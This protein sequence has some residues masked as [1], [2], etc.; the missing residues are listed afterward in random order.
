MIE[1]FSRAAA[2]VQAISSSNIR[3]VLETHREQQMN[4]L[5]E[6]NFEQRGWINVLYLNGGIVGAYY[7]TNTSTTSFPVSEL[8]KWWHGES[9]YVRSLNLPA[10]AVR[11]ISMAC[12]WHPPAQSLLIQ[13]SGLENY[14]QVFLINKISGLLHVTDPNGELILP[15][16]DGFSLAREAV[17]SSARIE[18]GMPAFKHA[19][20]SSSHNCTVVLYEARPDT[21]SFKQLVL[22]QVI[23][24]VTSS[25]LS[26]YSQIVG[27]GLLGSMSNELNQIL[28]LNRLQMQL[29]GD[30]LD[31][32]HIFKSL[33]DATRS[34]N[35]LF[36]ALYTH[37]SHVIGGGLAGTLHKEAY[38]GLNPR[39]QAAIDEQSL[40]KILQG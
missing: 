24:E 14:L 28:R 22:R 31:D 17:Y 39:N 15:I 13:S 27:G 30:H 19:I 1:F 36:K 34:Y 12:E 16:M 32:S 33:E 9:A 20:Q 37:M 25:M 6:I 38:R 26:R 5:I 11:V 29:V 4:G 2:N 23:G 40:L 35:M 8:D 18:A 3:G 21:P 10:A 7:L